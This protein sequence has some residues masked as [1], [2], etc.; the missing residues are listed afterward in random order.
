MIRIV[1]STINVP[2][3]ILPLRIKILMDKK[4]IHNAKI[5]KN[6]K[7]EITDYFSVNSKESGTLEVVLKTDRFFVPAHFG[8]NKDT[9]RLAFQL[10]TIELL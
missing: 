10:E 8:E 2:N 4:T 6:E 7:F 1:G 9:R 3:S 5:D